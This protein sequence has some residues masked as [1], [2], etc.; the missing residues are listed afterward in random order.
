MLEVPESVE[1][2]LKKISEWETLIKNNSI[3]GLYNINSYSENFC[4]DILNIIFD[5]KLV[6][7][8]LFNK[9]QAA[10]DLKDDINSF[11]EWVT[12]KKKE[13]YRI[14]LDVPTFK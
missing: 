11:V 1:Y 13:N 9:N 12:I 14:N 3:A 4:R 2:I 6:N 8:N 5:L 10:I 7:A